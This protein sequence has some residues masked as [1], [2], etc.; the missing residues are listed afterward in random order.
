MAM[1]KQSVRSLSQYDLL[2]LEIH[3]MQ[4]KYIVNWSFRCGTNDGRF[5]PQWNRFI[6]F[7]NETLSLDTQFSVEN[8]KTW[9]SSSIKKKYVAVD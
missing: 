9:W 4:L 2:E 5:K 3:W 8:K 6:L 1:S 7:F